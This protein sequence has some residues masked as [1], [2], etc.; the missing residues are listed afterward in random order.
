MVGEQVGV[1][2]IVTVRESCSR[3]RYLRG[4]VPEITPSELQDHLR[5]MI[6]IL[7]APAEEQLAYIQDLGL[8]LDELHNQLDDAEFSSLPRYDRFCKKF[9]GRSA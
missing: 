1:P 2:S 3:L 5:E 7:A 6:A 8:P 9:A 4:S